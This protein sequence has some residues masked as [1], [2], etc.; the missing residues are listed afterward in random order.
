MIVADTD[1]LIEALR[2]REPA[3][4]RVAEALA[5]GQLATTTITAFELRSSADSD[6]T[7]AAIE[8]LLAPLEIL[9]FD[10]QAL[11]RAGRVRRSLEPAGLGIGM[12]GYL[13]AGICLARAATLL[14]RNRAHFGRVEG[15]S[16]AGHL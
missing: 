13:I 3:R 12:A 16:L 11:I 2:G 5:A 10:E 4:S 14:T 8:Q 6:R 15:L 7:R 1:V 9:P